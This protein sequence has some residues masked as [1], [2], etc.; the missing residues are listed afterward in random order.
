ME[1]PGS[2]QIIDKLFT[3]FHRPDGVGTGRA[4]ANFENIENADHSLASFLK[5]IPSACRLGGIWVMLEFA[6]G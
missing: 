2:L 1:L 4:D 3:G 6:A 5:L